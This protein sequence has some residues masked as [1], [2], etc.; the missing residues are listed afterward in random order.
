MIAELGH[1]GRLL[2]LLGVL[3]LG[4]GAWF[5]WGPRLPWLGRLPGDFV[6]G[7]DHWKI[8][9]PLGTCLLLSLILS[10]VFSLI[11]RK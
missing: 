10:L 9:L 11:G 8:Y 1:L 7:G 4:V 3:L 2:M 5:A 6:F